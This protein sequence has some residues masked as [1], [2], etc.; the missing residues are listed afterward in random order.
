MSA[1]PSA[2]LSETVPRYTSYPTAPH[3]HAGIGEKQGKQWISRLE[4]GDTVSLYVHVPFCDKLCWFCAC[5]TKHT[6]HYKPVADFLIRAY[7]VN[8]DLVEAGI[9]ELSNPGNVSLGVGPANHRLGNLVLGDHAGSLLEVLRQ[10]Q[11]LAQ[12]TFQR[13]GWPV[14][15]GNPA[16]L[17]FVLV[18][19]H[20]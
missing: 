6:L 9:N 13:S 17:C 5:H 15:V 16:C 4:S 18:P 20:G 10:R 19:A 1:H 7:L 3:F 8:V 11:F 14:L 12:F 2:A